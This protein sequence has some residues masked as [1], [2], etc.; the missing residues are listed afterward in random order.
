MKKLAWYVAVS[1]ATLAVLFLLWE[2]RTAVVLFIMSLVLGAILRPLVDGLHNHG[3]PRWLALVTTYI[4]VAALVTALG[5]TIG[6]PV[7]SEIQVLA[8]NLP[9][10]YEQLKTQWLNG[11]LFQQTIAKNLP[12]LNNLFQIVSS[13]QWNA[14]VQS[15]MGI[16]LGSIQVISETIMVIILS[17]YW[18]ADEEH[19]KRVWL[20]LLPSE[21][22]IR[23]RD[24]WQNIEK[25]TGSYLR[26]EIIQSLILL[27]ILGISYQ[28]MGLKYPALLALLG[29]IGWLFVWF[30]GLITVIPAFLAGLSISPG[31]GILAALMTILVL[32]FLEF[33]V[34]PKIFNRRR[35]SSF[36]VV[37]MVLIMVRQYGIIGFLAAP[38]MAVAIQAIAS[39]IFRTT[40]AASIP[41]PP[42]PDIQIEILKERINTVK[43]QTNSRATPPA[44]EVTNLI[45]RLEALITRADQEEQLKD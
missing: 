8:V 40:T 5:F 36:L 23:W 21:S 4:G 38:P 18:S 32:A 11:S 16:T 19:F 17:I 12:D 41:L 15:F 1:L 37:I 22:R 27:I 13:G 44:Q 34:E 45:E 7:F 35:V 24:V 33:V 43:A 28:L 42:P 9:N 20:S 26:S 2:F 6:R 29:A 3:L 25:E 30:G 10:N 31:I 14:F 39:Q